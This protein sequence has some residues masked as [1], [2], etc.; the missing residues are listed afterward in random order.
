MIPHWHREE[1]H[2]EELHVLVPLE[3]DLVLAVNLRVQV[4]LDLVHD[5]GGDVDEVVELLSALQYTRLFQS[6]FRYFFYFFVK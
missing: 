5:V 3:D 4:H 6:Q 1:G 2:V